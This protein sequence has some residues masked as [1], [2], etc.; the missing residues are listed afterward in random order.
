MSD[1]E[2]TKAIADAEVKVAAPP[3]RTRAQRLRLPLMIGVPAV[4]VAV[5][6]FAF[7]SGGRFVSTDNAYVKL[8]RA[9]ISASV[10][11]RVV[12]VGVT[13][14]QLV[15]K[16]DVLLRL[17]A[18]DEKVALARAEANY[19]SARFQAETKRAV[20]EERRADRDAAQ[21]MVMFASREA[22]R[23]RDLAGAGV[24]TKS[25]SDEATHTAAQARQQLAVAEHQVAS[26]LADIGGDPHRP[27]EEFPDVLAAKAELDQAQ[28]NLSYTNVVAPADGIVTKVDQVQVGNR[29]AQSQVLFFLVS[30][31]PWIEANFKEDQLAHMREGQPVTVTIDA[32][33]GELHGHVGSFSPGT[34]SSFSLLPPENATGNWVKIVQRLPVQVVLD[35]DLPP[36]LGAGLSA[37]VEVDTEPAQSQQAAA[38]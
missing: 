7:F 8:A 13:E 36:N 1:V 19:A 21:E 24:N 4:I 3:G 2:G 35:G 29:V 11:G 38:P 32:Y 33:D 31:R 37:D 27:T 14:N 18:A 20:Y 34:G 6:L 10:P 25:Q 5:A 17:D 15:R 26:A 9:G 23:S 22:T 28:L 30:G 16:G 12:D